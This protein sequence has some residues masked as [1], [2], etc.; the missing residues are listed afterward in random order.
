[1]SIYG[2]KSFL[3]VFKII[4][5]VRITNRITVI[6]YLMAALYS[7]NFKFSGAASSY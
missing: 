5:D 4:L 7:E 3:H 1:M 6:P 2:G